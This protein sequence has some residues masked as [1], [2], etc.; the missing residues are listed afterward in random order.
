MLLERRNNIIEISKTKFKK[1]N[2]RNK[3]QTNDKTKVVV[4]AYLSLSLKKDGVSNT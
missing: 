3:N 1:E 2:K 4:G